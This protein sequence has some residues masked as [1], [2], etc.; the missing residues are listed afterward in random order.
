MPRIWRVGIVVGL[1]ILVVGASFFVPTSAQEGGGRTLEGW[2]VSQSGLALGLA[3]VAL[4]SGWLKAAWLGAI[5]LLGTAAQLTL[6][7]PLWRSPE[8]CSR[9]IYVGKLKGVGKV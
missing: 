8:T 6:T 5:F 9:S 3:A 2:W 7:S 4:G 1:T